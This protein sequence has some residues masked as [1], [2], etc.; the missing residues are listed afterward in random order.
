MIAVV[1]NMNRKNIKQKQFFQ[2]LSMFSIGFGAGAAGVGTGAA[3]R[4]GSGAATPID[5]VQYW[6]FVLINIIKGL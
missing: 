5:S 1:V 3:S 4:C 6:K 2:Y